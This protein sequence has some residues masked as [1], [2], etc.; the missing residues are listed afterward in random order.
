LDPF[1]S[2]DNSAI[3]MEITNVFLQFSVTLPKI[4]KKIMLRLKDPLFLLLATSPPETGYAIL[5]HLKF[6]VQKTPDLFY[7]HFREFYIK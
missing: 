6:M 4:Q 5:V 7:Y 1:I 3:V 2:I